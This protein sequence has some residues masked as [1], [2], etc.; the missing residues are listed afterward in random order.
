MKYIIEST[1]QGWSHSCSSEEEV[2]QIME[3]RRLVYEPN[4]ALYG[5]DEV[6]RDQ[7]EALLY[8]ADE[9]PSYPAVASVRFAGAD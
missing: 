8:P 4:V 1:G 9:P 2:E 7:G 3:G 5:L 6:V